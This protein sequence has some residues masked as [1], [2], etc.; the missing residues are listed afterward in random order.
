MRLV[1]DATR[2][3][4][5]KIK[6]LRLVFIWCLLNLLIAAAF[7]NTRLGG[8]GGGGVECQNKKF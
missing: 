4:G 6:S 2:G 8:G 7:F 1:C 3:G 5:E